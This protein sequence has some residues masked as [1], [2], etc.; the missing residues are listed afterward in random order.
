MDYHRGTLEAYTS[1]GVIDAEATYSIDAVWGPRQRGIRSLWHVNDCTLDCWIF[2]G[3]KQS[4]AT[5]VALLGEEEVARQE[6][7]ACEKWM[8]TAAQDD[9]DGWGDYRYGLA[10]E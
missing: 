5:A 7:L 1:G 2:D 8:E 10:A 6:D 3:R 4:R 9:A